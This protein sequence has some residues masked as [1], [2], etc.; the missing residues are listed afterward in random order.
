MTQAPA[1]ADI[2]PMTEGQK[3]EFKDHLAT[4]MERMVQEFDK[5]EW[6]YE[7][8]GNDL[9]L[10]GNAMMARIFHAVLLTSCA[11]L[12]RARCACR[13]VVEMSLEAGGIVRALADDDQ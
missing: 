2:K 1:T 9:M 10:G 13:K 4:F 5:M 7:S 6:G 8:H 11:V 12:L 3:L